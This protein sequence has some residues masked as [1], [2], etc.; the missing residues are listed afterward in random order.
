MAEHLAICDCD[1]CLYVQ[2]KA[3]EPQVRQ[4]A[5]ARWYQRDGLALQ[6]Y[7]ERRCR[8]LRCVEHR[9]DLLHDCF[10]IGFRNVSSGRFVE[11]GNS[12]RA[13]L[14]GIAR[15]LVNNLA[16]FLYSESVRSD[17]QLDQ[18]VVEKI[19][20]EDRVY[21]EEVCRIVREEEARQPDLVRLIVQGIYVEGKSSDEV[22]D[23]LSKSAGNVRIIASRAV[24]RMSEQLEHQHNLHIS[25]FAIR[26]CLE[27]LA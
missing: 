26:S 9:D 17:E 12:L 5:W 21:L 11:Q 4:S 6:K 27:C 3:P 22:A 7:L 13:Y 8:I 1:R 24:S 16:R 2:M 18:P 23:E 10:V 15:H 20:M 25:P 14:Y 19:T